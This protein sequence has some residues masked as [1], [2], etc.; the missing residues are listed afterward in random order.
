ME[1][2]DKDGV[3]P[4]FERVV[5]RDGLYLGTEVSRV[6]HYSASAS[7]GR[8]IVDAAIE[9]CDA[10]ALTEDMDTSR[11]ERL[12]S[13]WGISGDAAELHRDALVWDMTLPIITPGT[14]ERKAEIFAR[15][16][17]A[18]FDLQSITLAIDGMDSG[19]PGIRSPC[20][21]P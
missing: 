10:F 6:R 21:E 7:V 14:P 4:G 3:L 17:V 12:M 5:A 1:T 11:G 20:I 18:G 19:R 9:V 8:R 16:A 15:S 2:K 13:E